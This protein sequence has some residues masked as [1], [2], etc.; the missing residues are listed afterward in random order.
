MTNEFQRRGQWETV[1]GADGIL[2]PDGEKNFR[3]GRP[4]EGGE[5]R[6][7]KQDEKTETEKR[8]ST[9]AKL[10]SLKR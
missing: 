2:E 9:L 10:R 8:V 3:G 1:V 6:G 7:V 5:S 4:Q